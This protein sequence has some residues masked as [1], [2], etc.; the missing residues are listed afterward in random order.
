MPQA[1]SSP[2]V[3]TNRRFAGAPARLARIVSY[4]L[5]LVAVAAVAGTLAVAFLI[6]DP[7]RL[8]VPARGYVAHE[9][10]VRLVW[11]RGDHQGP[12]TVQVAAGRDFS[13]PLVDHSTLETELVLPRLPA[14]GHYCWRV[15]ATS[16]AEVSCFDTAPAVVAY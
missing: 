11:R 9:P 8:Q 7:P 3:A 5:P 12:F 14:G 4:G 1:P 13:R 10:K 6:A 2:P 16:S 15:V